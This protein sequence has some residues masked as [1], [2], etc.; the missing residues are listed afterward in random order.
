MSKRELIDNNGII[1]G[2]RM[3]GE[4]V[5]QRNSSR[6]ANRNH[7]VVGGPGSYKSQS[8]VVTNLLHEKVSS[9]VVTDP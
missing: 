6:L 5:L 9:L 1:V 2:R 8:Y 4:I 7:L 3:N